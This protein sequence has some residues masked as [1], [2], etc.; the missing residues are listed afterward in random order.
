MNKLK[1]FLG[2]K[3]TIEELSIFYK[4]MDIKTNEEISNRQ[5]LHLDLRTKIKEELSIE[6]SIFLTVRNNKE[7]IAYIRFISDFAYQCYIM[8]VMVLPDY[9][10]KKIGK[11]ML[12]KVIRYAK[13]LKI[14]KIFLFAVPQ[15][16]SYYRQFNFKNTIS[17]ALEIRLC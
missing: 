10:N 12:L 17:Q 3:V 5:I 6:N 9:Q 16:E 13:K 2:D 4:K 8:E 11:T 14:F 1:Y 7:L 15:R